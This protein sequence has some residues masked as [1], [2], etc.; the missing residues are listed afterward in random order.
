MLTFFLNLRFIS[1]ILEKVNMIMSN[2]SSLFQVEALAVQLTEREGELIQEKS[3][4]KKLANFLKQVMCT[5][6]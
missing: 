4:V 6:Y 5:L 2:Y 1:I 3:E